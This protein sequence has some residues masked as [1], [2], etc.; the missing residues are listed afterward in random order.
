MP[1]SA[2]GRGQGA[3]GFDPRRNRGP[4]Q[5]K[6]ECVCDDAPT[7]NPPTFLQPPSVFQ[8]SKCN[9]YT[10]DQKKQGNASAEEQ[11][12]CDGRHT[13][14]GDPGLARILYGPGPIQANKQ[15]AIAGASKVQFYRG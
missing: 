9:A 4:V 5:K 13:F 12:E 3:I 14:A 7:R 1:V 15:R 2:G 8:S 6:R 10:A 11:R